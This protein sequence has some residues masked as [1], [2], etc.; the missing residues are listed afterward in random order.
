VILDAIGVVALLA[1]GVLVIVMAALLERSGPVR[2]RHW[3]EEAG[4]SLLALF[5][6][7]GRFEGYRFLLSALAKSVPVLLVVALGALFE[8]MRLAYPVVWALVVVLGLVAALELVN[9]RLVA[10]RAEE[11]L[12]RLTVLYRAFLVTLSPLATLAGR[13][14][15]RR[16]PGEDEEPE[17]EIG[18]DTISDE[19]VEA[20]IELGTREGILEP[21]E[22]EYVW[23]IVDFG[24]TQV[25]SV[26]TPRV[27]M[28]VASADADLDELAERFLESGYSRIPLYDESV[29]KIAGILHI[30]EL[31]RGLR[32]DPRPLAR[33]LAKP[34]M[35][36][37]ER[38]PL[39]ELLREMQARFQQV[40]IVL[41]EYGGTAGLV[42]VEDLL[43]E[44][45]GEIFDED[46]VADDEPV[47]APLPDGSW[48]LDGRAHVE[49]LD[50]LFDLDLEEEPYETVGGLVLAA[51]GYVPAE[52][53]A[54][55]HHGLRF[56]V[57]DV[58]GRRVRTVRVEPV[59]EPATPAQEAEEVS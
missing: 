20:Y 38:K 14:A 1:L 44:I 29:D 45:V 12:E 46:E 59:V 5:E 48:R 35:F 21:G 37:P 47:P 3:A 53:E 52:G 23:G 13:F 49:V 41:D 30:R 26:M 51:C 32:S 54:V 7:P 2:V 36:V 43:E 4:G 24:D 6:A 9:R 50:E 15:L 28:V 16:P 42:T 11:T 19:E 57:E 39:D 25:R 27:D 31:L 34:A 56:H 40:A 33:D 18:E 8:E 17:I 55:E 10:S 22:E 58:T